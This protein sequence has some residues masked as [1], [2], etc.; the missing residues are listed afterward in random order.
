M[1]NKKLPLILA[2]LFVLS[3]GLVPPTNPGLASSRES[4][5]PLIQTMLSQVDQGEVINLTGGLSGE[6]PVLIDAQPY[7]ITTRHALSGEPIQKAT[8][9]LYEYY[10][11]LGLET[12]YQEFSFGGKQLSNVIA[13]K[14]GTVFPERIFMIT[15]HFDDIVNS[16][17]LPTTMLIPGADDDASGTVG[18]ML[19]A[20]ILSQYDFGCTLRF[21]NFNAEEYGMIGSEDYAHQAYCA[22]EDIRGVINLDMIAWNTSQSPPEMDLHALATI[23]GSSL[24]SDTFKDTVSTYGLGI[25]PTDADPVVLR[26]D[27]ASFWG[28][29]IPAI[30][31]SEDI[32]DFNP[33]YHSADDTLGNLQDLDYFTDM[34]KASLGTLA[35][36]GCLV[37]NGWG[38]INGV[39][40]DENT[41]LPVPNASISL[42]NP[43]WGYTFNTHTDQ[44]GAYQI[45]ALQ[46]L[47]NLTVDGIGY[48]AA[49]YS[50]LTITRDQNTE[51]D[52]E[53]SPLDEP[54]IYLPLASNLTN[55]TPAGL[56]GCP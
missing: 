41:L 7:T 44:N 25:S 12:S 51:L 29:D 21:A 38:T 45:S 46:G 4:W 34:I 11:D 56:A 20:K 5:S 54:I 8:Q 43:E 35:Q 27:H 52:I 53:L 18:V 28:Y 9:Y 16:D 40:T 39:V 22:G 19:A 49:T 31:V 47:H 26:S 32:D 6:W 10:Q 15:S 48:A 42:H 37:E 50:A 13:Q 3:L 55:H 24:I 23:P 36:M 33:N 14:T 30:L 2:I 1:P 17:D